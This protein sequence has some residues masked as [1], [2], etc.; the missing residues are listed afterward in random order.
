MSNV[1][2]IMIATLL[3]LLGSIISV[4][5]IFMIKYYKDVLAIEREKQIKTEEQKRVTLDKIN[6]TK[7]EFN[8][9]V[10]RYTK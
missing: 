4:L 8:S 10:R 1:E 9:F 5:A 7:S 6:G 3:L 2:L